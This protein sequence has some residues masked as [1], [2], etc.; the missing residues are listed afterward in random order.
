MFNY[1][2]VAFIY[3]KFYNFQQIICFSDFSGQIKF[4]LNWFINHTYLINRKCIIFLNCWPTTFH[5]IL[6]RIRNKMTWILEKRIIYRNKMKNQLI[7]L[8]G[9]RKSR[10]NTAI[11][12]EYMLLNFINCFGYFVLIFW[13]EDMQFLLKLIKHQNFKRNHQW[14]V[15]H[16]YK[17]ILNFSSF[18][19]CCALESLEKPSCYRYCCHFFSRLKVS[20]EYALLKGQ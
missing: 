2:S 3:S 5:Q 8:R 7:L 14:Q 19:D 15:V 20:L 18:I 12:L 11:P 1:I 17:C 10:S 13:S 16:F 6:Q 9:R 4:H